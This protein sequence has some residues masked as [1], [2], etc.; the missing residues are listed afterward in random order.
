MKKTL[1]LLLALSAALSL[2]AATLS[3]TVKDL[4]TNKA[5]EF[6]NIAVYDKETD[7]IKTGTMSGVDGVFRIFNIPA[8]NYYLIVTYMGYEQKR[9][10][11]VILNG[12][13]VD[14]GTIMLTPTA[15][16]MDNVVRT[17]RHRDRYS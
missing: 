5:L 17:R 9:H 15:L 1:L 10:D 8:G 12:K 14:V 2:S 3:G 16:K 13:N 6:A 4:K 11:N 7:E